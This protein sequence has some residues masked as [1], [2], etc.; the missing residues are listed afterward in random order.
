MGLLA[1]WV[2]RGLFIE[3]A[4]CEEAAVQLRV[5]IRTT[6]MLNYLRKVFVYDRWANGEVLSS[7]VSC[8]TPSGRSIQLLAHILSAQKLWFERMMGQP[9]SLPV[10]PEYGFKECEALQLELAEL[11]QDYFETLRD[12]EL[13]RRVEYKNSKGEKFESRVEDIL[14][15]VAMHGTYHRGQIAAD[16]RAAGMT[17]A[18]TDFIHAVRQSF[19][20]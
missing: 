4:I 2:A 17:P 15:H 16:M 10:W 11:W 18:Y 12:G 9:Q 3:A 19:V 14:T 6:R 5:W 7:L 13:E 1:P 8:K 20:R